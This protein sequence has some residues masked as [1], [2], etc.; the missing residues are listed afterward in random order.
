MKK[1]FIVRQYIMAESAKQAIKFSKTSPVS[2]V[3]IDEEWKK[4]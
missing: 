3:W 2:D 1:L 4:V